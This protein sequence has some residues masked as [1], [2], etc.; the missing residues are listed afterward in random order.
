MKEIHAIQN[1]DG[2]FHV[3]ITNKAKKKRLFGR[4]GKEEETIEGTME[5]E[6][7]I[8]EVTPLPSDTEQL[9]AGR[10]ML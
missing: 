4:F 2:S 6:R 8:I 9:G 3:T 10:I 1:E 7:A 5:C